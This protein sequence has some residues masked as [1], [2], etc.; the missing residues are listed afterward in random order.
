[1]FREK[2]TKKHLL[3]LPFDHSIK[4]GGRKSSKQAGKQEIFFATFL[5]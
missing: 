3:N 2:S 1:M 5:N 4:S